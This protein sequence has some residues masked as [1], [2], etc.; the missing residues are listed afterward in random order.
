MFLLFFKSN[1]SRFVKHCVSQLKYSYGPVDGAN[2]WCVYHLLCPLL[3]CFP[4]VNGVPT[5]AVDC[6]VFLKIANKLIWCCAHAC[7]PSVNLC[8][9]DKALRIPKKR[10][11]VKREEGEARTL[12]NIRML[13]ED[14]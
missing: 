13:E 11:S 14:Q 9:F 5:E 4:E 2:R 10:Y 6:I 3:G 7:K 12:G 8:S 1:V